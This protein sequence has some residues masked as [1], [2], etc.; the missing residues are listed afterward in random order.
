MS[1]SRY[2]YNRFPIFPFTVDLPM[3]WAAS[4]IAQFSG[5]L[6]GLALVVILSASFNYTNLS[7]A[8]A[9]RRSREVGTRKVIGA[10]KSNVALQFITESIIVSLLALVFSFLLFLVLR[11]Q[12]LFLHPFLSSRFALELTPSLILSFVTLAV[13]VGLISGFLLH[14]SSRAFKPAKH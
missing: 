1:R 4:F 2:G 5:F 14:F 3:N 10:T 6:S 11:R 13:V 9:F 7:V 8:R 12:F